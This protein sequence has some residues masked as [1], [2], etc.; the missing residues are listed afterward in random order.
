[1]K[2]FLACARLLLAIGCKP[3]EETATPVPAPV[4]GAGVAL[5]ESGPHAA[6]KRVFNT[7]GCRNCHTIGADASGPAKQ[8]KG[9]KTQGP[10]LASVAKDPEHTS[11]WLADFVRDPK[12]KYSSSRMPA[13]K[14]KINDE[15]FKALIE[16]LASLN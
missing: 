1:M 2:R 14:S 11:E 6:G 9:G 3:S 13:F 15:D 10:D 5:D 7:Q 12:S 4:P 8:G 16:Y